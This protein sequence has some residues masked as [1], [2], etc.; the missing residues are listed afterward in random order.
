ME[1]AFGI[2]RVWYTI[3]AMTNATRAV[4]TMFQRDSMESRRMASHE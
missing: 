3:P 1:I 2:N 4:A